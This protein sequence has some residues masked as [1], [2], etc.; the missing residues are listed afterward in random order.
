EDLTI[1][2]ELTDLFTPSDWENCKGIF[3]VDKPKDQLLSGMLNLKSVFYADIVD[4]AN[5]DRSDLTY[6][7]RKANGID[8][9]SL[10]AIIY[11]SGTTG[12]PKGVMLTHGNFIQNI[13]ANTPRL[14]INEE[15]HYST[16]VML[17]SWHVFER[18]YEYCCLFKGVRLYYSKPLTFANDLSREK[19]DLFIT[20]PRVWES[21]YQKLVKEIS[22]KSFI[23]RGIF[24]TMTRIRK[25]FLMSIFYLRGSYLRFRK[26]NIFS[27]ISGIL[28]HASRIVFL[29]PL[30]LLTNPLTKG[31]KKKLGGNV[32]SAVCGAGALPKHLDE[33]FNSLGITICNAYGMTEC[34]PGIIARTIAR[35]T[36]GSTG[37][38][39]L[40][41]EI[42]IIKQDGS[43]AKIG[44]KG[45]LHCRGPQVMKGYYN[46]PEATNA[47]LSKDGWLNTGDLAVQSANGEYI[48]V[49]REKD[50]IVL[51]G[52]ENVE[53]E[54][55][56]NKLKECAFIDHAI[57]VGNDRKHLSAIIAINDDQLMKLAGEL[58]L[59]IDTARLADPDSVVHEK[60]SE[61]LKAEVQKLIS[62][63]NGFKHFE[64]IQ[65]ITAIKHNFTIGAELT[66]SLK[67]KRKFVEEKYKTL[68]ENLYAETSKL[69]KKPSKKQ[70][71][72]VK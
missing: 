63:E 65:K 40:N 23:A 35:N 51:S 62:R 34:A 31:I 10:S 33:L 12:N 39:F 68:L 2:Q 8:G 48:L 70:L 50:T 30:W 22:K 69:R 9:D 26:N 17:P 41:T 36:F 3:I 61:R 67:V 27:R 52:G 56:E 6:L 25:S 66:Q 72:A 4:Q 60:I 16:V 21:I 57:V 7:E 64:M 43:E 53:P 42:K 59:D 49:G 47:V 11:T 54:Q 45:V 46:N 28:F 37:T 71:S 44:E 19:P 24:V 14:E 20:V 15:K 13:V 1:A 18:T 38:P 29:Y 32:K 55:I 58:K 5:L